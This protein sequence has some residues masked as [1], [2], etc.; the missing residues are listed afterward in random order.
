MSRVSAIY[1]G[2]V[3]HRRFEPREHRFTYPLFLMYLDLDELDKLFAGRW[4]WSAR[5]PALARFDRRDH[6]GNPD[7][8]LREAVAELVEAHT[9]HRPEGPIRLLTHLRYFGHCFNPV[10]FY[11]CFDAA[12]ERLQ[13]VVA[14]VNNTPWGE[15][16]CYVLDESQNLGDEARKRYRAQK[17]FHVSPFM[18]LDYEYEWRLSLPEDRLMV[19]IKNL[20]NGRRAFDATM[21]LERREIDGGSLARVLLRHPLMTLRVVFWIHLEALKLWLKRVPFHPHPGKLEAGPPPPE[22]SA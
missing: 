20:R 15:R 16:H 7:V 17:V 22:A 1:E 9:G 10:C 6:L 4:L 14:E 12:G 21:A 19:H 3:R 2:T 13:T 8:P 18:D 11:F 5:R